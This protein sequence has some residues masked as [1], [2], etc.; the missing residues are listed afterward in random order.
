M[1]PSK[2]RGDTSPAQYSLQKAVPHPTQ[3]QG[4]RAVCRRSCSRRIALG[5]VWFPELLARPGYPRMATKPGSSSTERRSTTPRGAPSAALKTTPQKGICRGAAEGRGGQPS[6]YAAPRVGMGL[7]SFC[8]RDDPRFGC[9]QPGPPAQTP[10]APLTQEQAGGKSGPRG[11]GVRPRPAVPTEGGWSPACEDPCGAQGDPGAKGPAGRKRTR[12]ACSGTPQGCARPL[13]CRGRGGGAGSPGT[14]QGRES[15]PGKPARGSRPGRGREVPTGTPG[16]RVL[17]PLTWKNA[18]SAPG[19]GSARLC[20]PLPS[21]PSPPLLSRGGGGAGRG[22]PAPVR[23][24]CHR[25]RRRAGPDPSV[26]L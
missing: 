18:K 1:K 7:G 16:R 2:C 20:P 15:P 8:E 5:G 9:L 26:G 10:A 6:R 17:P 19:P 11:G 25:R 12:A 4:R 3:R 24:P 23:P 13:P 21:P 22:R 14:G